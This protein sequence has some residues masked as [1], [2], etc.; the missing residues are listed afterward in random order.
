[1][2]EVP[3]SRAAARKATSKLKNYRSDDESSEEQ[4]DD[5]EEDLEYAYEVGHIP[6]YPSL[7]FH[8]YLVSEITKCSGW[9]RNRTLLLFFL[10]NFL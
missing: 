8:I 1:V 3:L 10:L 4:N 9:L 6:E 2:K 5:E 7:N